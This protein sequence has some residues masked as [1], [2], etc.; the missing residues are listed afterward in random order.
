[1]ETDRRSVGVSRNYQ[2]MN[3]TV[4]VSDGSI[5]GGGGDG[6]NVYD[7]T[8]TGNSG[9]GTS[10]S[11][12]ISIS[13]HN[14]LKYVLFSA[15]SDLRLFKLE[16]SGSYYYLTLARYGHGVG[17]SQRGAQ[18]MAKEGESYKSIINFY[19]DGVSLPT[20]DFKREELTRYTPIA[21]KPI[22][23]ATV[24]SSTLRVRSDASSS[25]AKL[26]TL[27]RGTTVDVYAN[28][29]DWL[30]VSFNGSMGYISS[31]Y[32]TLTDYDGSEVQPARQRRQQQ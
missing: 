26:G 24:T 9:T 19:F 1:M 25:S 31:S 32:V 6:S 17:M 22:A 27:S 15:D 28:L 11:V 21:T 16:T 7:D 10:Q 30:C 18:Q 23:Q 3:M 14:E 2:T 8:W 12:D 20:I 13:L 4:L 5:W 29:G